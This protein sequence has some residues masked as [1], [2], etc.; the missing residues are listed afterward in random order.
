MNTLN[1]FAE[2]YNTDKQM[3]KHNYVAVYESL[4]SPFRQ[5][6]FNFL[7]IGIYHGGSIR[8]WR[9][10]FPNATIYGIDIRQAHI[11]KIKDTERLVL[12]QVDQGS[13]VWLK[14]YAKQGPWKVIIDDG[15]HKSS[16]QK[17]TFD[18]LWDQVQP[19][20][21]YIIEDTHTSYWNHPVFNW[22]DCDETLVQRMLRLADEVSSA[23]YHK[24]DYNNY[25]ILKQH[26]DLTKHQ[27]EVEYI[28]FRM[29]LIIIKKRGGLYGK[30]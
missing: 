15:S 14:E 18:V 21:Y 24:G 10:Y 8:M 7:E 13:E 29:G 30:P 23:T 5:D 26:G 19:G 28:Q 25:F 11:N 17:L 27:I 12:N 22:I 20:G 6:T 1:D 16:H 4:F 9:D 3:N 2:E